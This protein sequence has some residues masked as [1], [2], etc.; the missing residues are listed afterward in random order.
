[1]LFCQQKDIPEGLKGDTLRNIYFNENPVDK[2]R[3]QFDD[4]LYSSKDHNKE[5][6]Y[7]NTTIR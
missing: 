7:L 5:L 6:G 2:Y 4:C 3:A 1:M